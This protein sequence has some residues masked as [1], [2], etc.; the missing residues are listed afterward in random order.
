MSLASTYIDEGDGMDVYLSEVMME[1][2]KV[3]EQ[4]EE[5][6]DHVM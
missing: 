3:M 5:V 2:G 6:Q 4:V 1:W